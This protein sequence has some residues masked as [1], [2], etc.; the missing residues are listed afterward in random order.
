MAMPP[1]G[2]TF[3][4]TAGLCA[5]VR[6]VIERGRSTELALVFTERHLWPPYTAVAIRTDRS[7]AGGRNGFFGVLN[8]FQKPGTFSV[9]ARP[10]GL[11]K[12]GAGKSSMIS[13]FFNCTNNR[14]RLAT[15]QATWSGR[16]ARS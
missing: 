10:C 5:R 14:G 13:V 8:N 1:Q 3:N 12:R 9:G 15:P 7:R 16:D 2:A 6:G 4:E 11:N